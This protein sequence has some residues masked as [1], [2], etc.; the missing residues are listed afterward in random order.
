MVPVTFKHVAI[1]RPNHL[2][3]LW[4]FGEALFAVT[5]GMG[6]AIGLVPNVKSVT[7]AEFVLI[8][9]VGIVTSTYR[10]DVHL[11]HQG[12]VTF[13]SVKTDDMT[14]IWV[15]FVAVHTFY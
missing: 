3:V 14:R 4:V 15:V 2:L 6:F 11:F 5:L 8:R 9:V 13:H 1:A 12:D 10:V 7:V